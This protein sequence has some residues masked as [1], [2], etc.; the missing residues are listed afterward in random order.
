LVHDPGLAGG[1]D[2]ADL[3]CCVWLPR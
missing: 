2:E 1:R 3:D